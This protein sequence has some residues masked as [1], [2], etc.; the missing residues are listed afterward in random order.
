MPRPKKQEQDNTISNT[1][2]HF[3]IIDSSAEEDKKNY[4][5][6]S[7]IEHILVRP[8]T[9]IGSIEKTVEDMFI[10]DYSNPEEPMIL[11]KT[12]EYI[13]G[14]YKIF[15][16][17]LVNATDH[18]TRLTVKR[19]QG[20]TS[21]IPV[22]NIKVDIEKE[23]G[24]ITV[25]NDGD[26]IH[27]VEID[28][29][30][31]YA[32]ELIFGHLLTGTNYNDSEERIVGGQNGYGAKLANIFSTEFTIETVDKTRNLKYIQTF[33]NN[34]TVRTEPKITTYSSK[35]YTR[36][37]F[38]PDYKRFGLDGLTSD[39]ISLLEKRV[40][41]TAAWTNK[42]ISV[43]LNNTRLECK[44]FEKYIDLYIGPKSE[45]P[46]VHL[47]LGDRWEVIATY[48][49]CSN[50]EQVS[51]VNGI[52]TSRGGKH[53]EYI[54]SQIRDGLVDYIKKKKKVMVKPATIR[55][56]LFIFLKSTITNPSFDS[57]T[58]ETL[59]TPVSKF[60]SVATI[61]DKA[62]DKIAKIGIMERIM[63]AVDN[64]N[65]KDF[66]KTDGK[67]QN[68]IR[69]LP[70]L[71][72]ADMAGTKDSKKC[73]LILT[74]GD[75]AKSSVLSGLGQ[76]GR[77]YYGVFPLRGKL[78]NVKDTDQEKVINNAEIQAIKK[79]LG[80]KA[81]VD[82]SVET[83]DEL[84]DLRYGKIMI[85]CDSDVDGS[86]IKG[87][88]MNLFHSYWPS[89]LQAGFVITMLTP[90]VKVFKGKVS[91]SFYNLGDY[92]TWKDNNPDHH[93]YEVKYYK[94]LG[95]SSA[96]E[97]KEYFK[98][99]KVLNYEWTDDSNNAIDLAFNKKR[100]DDR[101]KWLENY[102]IFNVLD[103]TKQQVPI[104]DFI[105]K[106]LIHF[107]N[108]DNI[109]SIP[110]VCDGLKPSQRKILYSAFKRNLYKE[111]KVAQFAGYVSEHAAYHHGEVSLQGTITGMAQNF[112]GS[113]NISLFVP[114][115]AFGTRLSLGKDAA[116]ARYIFT[117]LHPITSYIYRQ[118]DLPIMSY[119]DD[120]GFSIE[121]T[122]YMPIIPMILIN[123]ATGIGTG[124]SSDVPSHN[125]KDI[126]TQLLNLLDGK[127]MT[128][129][130]PW[131]CGFKGE[132][133]KLSA[134]TQYVSKGKYTIVDSNTIEITEIPIGIS[135]EK[136]KEF[137]EDNIIDKS[138]P[139]KK[140]FIKTYKESCVD[141]LIS[142]NVKLDKVK[143]DELEG[144]PLELEKA[145]KLIDGSKT[146]YSNMHLY[147][148]NIHI[149][150]YAGPYDI[151]MEFY[152]L[153]LE[154]YEKRKVY[155]LGALK[156]ELDLLKEKYRFISMIID[157]QIDVRGKT[158]LSVESM[159]EANTF[160]KLANT[161]GKETS[162][163]YLVQMPIYSQT[164]EKLDELK[165]KLDKKQK[166]HDD[167]LGRDIK[168]IWR[169]ELTQLSMEVTKY[170]VDYEQM[171]SG[172]QVSIKKGKAKPK[173]K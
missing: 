104:E 77:D 110:N 38:I 12:I 78:L 109:R 81:G 19:N 52:H 87:L 48:N 3:N 135:T 108:Y 64:K 27:V 103:Y 100:A 94:G 152:G 107:S 61:D 105:N 150:K 148:S 69:G 111:I 31:C 125:P 88:L 147:D 170:Y 29:H 163:D 164:K 85:L 122:F 84:W 28:E 155:Q 21:I 145:F 160:L 15:D 44:T 113:N 73:I 142:F 65:N 130:K 127:P 95:T 115:G 71:N 26:G 82:Y 9:Y 143:L 76:E 79:I 97:F 154:Y 169:D 162:F 172:E 54:V 116:S 138:N 24:R 13:P 5:K 39:I 132:I 14:L 92:K 67:K 159:L 42:T 58:K 112:V 121:P 101:K 89:L 171:L 173:K 47:E 128:G 98:D 123:G 35:P 1:I 6:L 168:D 2:E 102:D 124:Y 117:H 158:K 63:N 134:D 72:D 139:N 75:S 66:Q 16:E 37:S 10:M 22:S 68:V 165:E 30:S 157:N 166:E 119:L 114:N 86:H 4:K 43:F 93:L 56:E 151:I 167:L 17:I 161:V 91:Q 129:I 141:N 156:N 74:E 11:K 153:R 57:Q 59:T 33:T 50:F 55:N 99:M 90:I 136:Y 140:Q 126:I 34:M 18:D 36:I 46:R 45:H 144:D 53:L 120:D 32:P 20:D 60:G 106:D 118:E 146:S 40:Y 149:Y 70:K 62:I 96:A 8:S 137:L 80:L 49:S 7:H 51:F 83:P 25:Y 131:Y 23:T 41:D 133:L